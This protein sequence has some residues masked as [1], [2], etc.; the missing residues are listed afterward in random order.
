ML[1]EKFGSMTNLLEIFAECQSLEEVKI[2]NCHFA[3][4]FLYQE[5]I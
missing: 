5:L 2:I 1:E 3:R 4:A